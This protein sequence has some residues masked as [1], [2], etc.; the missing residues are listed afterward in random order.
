MEKLTATKRDEMLVKMYGTIQRLDERTEAQ[1]KH[2]QVMNDNGRTRDK[3]ITR[4][5]I[6]L[7]S[8]VCLLIGGG[9]V[10]A[11]ITHLILG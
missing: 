5:E 10:D 8:L 11:N 3:R 6:G 4:L 2:L 9:L 7:A 1:E